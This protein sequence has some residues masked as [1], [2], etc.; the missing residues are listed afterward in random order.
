[1]AEPTPDPAS[2]KRVVRRRDQLIDI[3]L[4][5]ASL[6]MLGFIAVGLL[7]H[8]GRRE[9]SRELAES[10][11]RERGIDAVVVV[12]DLDASG[13]SG[14]IRVGP[15]G[16][17][18]FAADRIEVAYDL[19]APWSGG[20]FALD[21]RAVRLVRPRL[22]ASIDDQGRLNFGPLQPLID[23]ALAAPKDPKAQGPAILVENARLDLRTPGG[24]ARITGDASLD[25]GKLL[26]FDGR[27]GRTR[28]ATDDLVVE[29]RGALL[30][31]RKRGE[32]L[33]MSARFDLDALVREDLE[34]GDAQGQIEADLAYPDL[35]RLSAVGPAEI[36]T[37]FTADAARLGATR[38]S[39]AT[40]SLA[41]LGR[42]DGTLAQAR[43]DGRMTSRVRGEE[44]DAP[45]L[46]ARDIGLELDL[47]KLA[48][49]RQ[50]DRTAILTSGHVSADA[51]QALIGGA[52]LRGA[53]ARIDMA[54]LILSAD[55]AGAA[56]SGPLAVQLGASRLA[57]GGLALTS[58]A[59]N[60]KGRISGPLSRPAL[61][62]SGSA[63]ADSG[64]S[65]PD[66]ER[67]AALLPDPADTRA[68]AQALRTFDLRAP[69]FDLTLR[70]GH[71]ILALPRPITLT[72]A[73]GVEASIAAPRGPLLDAVAGQAR[74]GLSAAFSGGGLPNLKLDAPDWRMVDGTVNARIVLAG[75]HID[76]PPLEGVAGQID[77]QVA[78]SGARS[79]FAL[80]GC[81]P[82]TATRVLV[83]ETP[84]SA[85][86]LTLCPGEGPLLAVNDGA[87]TASARFRDL[88]S[89]LDE[90][91]A[92][93]EDGAGSLTAS[94]RG[95]PQRAEVR[96][97]Q[98][99]L[100]DAAETRRF[101]PIKTAGRLSL[102]NGL[103][104]GTIDATTPVGQP[105]GRITLRHDLARARGRAELDASKLA[106]AKDGLQP[107][108]LSPLAS[109][110]TQASGPASF[111]GLFVWDA[112]GMTSQGRLVASKIDFTSPIGFVA[113]L[114]GTVD[115]TS[116]TPLVS[117]PDQSLKIV[118]IDSLV[119]LEGFAAAFSLGAE[120]LHIS[121]A[122]FQAAK[123]RVSIEPTDVPLDPGKPIRGVIVVRHLDLGEL[124]AASSLVE[125]IQLDAVVDGR[126]P[127]ELS[128]K[129]F[130]FL[131]GK[132]FAIQ[133]GRLAISREALTGV[134]A[135]VQGQDGDS[136][137]APKPPASPDAP[138]NAIQDFAYQAMENLAFTALEAGVT[139]TDKGRLAILFH[140][141]GEHDPKVP[142]KARIGLMDLIR[143]SAFNKRI[144]LPA[145][146]PVDLTLDTSLNFDELLEAWRRAYKGEDPEAPRSAPVQP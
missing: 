29:A 1:M 8:A 85:P 107:G 102:S 110:A 20:P 92:T 115:F 130:R 28:Y 97:D 34:L 38:A 146:T 141:K 39:G 18:V 128:P 64:V 88:A 31:A 74:G 24:L 68:G 66:A 136:P 55:K 48:A 129:G 111:T 83:G 26:R 101:N 84:L 3:G 35:V 77:G 41:L 96:L 134:Q 145:K 124:I 81:R 86:K 126:L 98:G 103:W 87:W 49:S 11:L 57:S 51:A 36:R 7:I 142:E 69:A 61:T 53:S 76:V 112:D 73:N 12:D 30:S 72:A 100:R 10:W 113:T 9:I 60:A 114:D 21:T 58:L 116:L 106:F 65:G 43:F 32:R 75:D 122:A 82:L 140:I 40:V 2:P 59:A 19:T 67:L 78:L 109:W 105:L 16:D 144:P 54:G 17:P 63:G 118:R 37:A 79:T 44:L 52:A 99:V 131:D 127:F 80:A 5:A 6:S 62:L 27:L 125:K 70:D 138:V 123:G 121:S 14:A 25:D 46:S 133:P 139:S 95:A 90:A 132:V 45:D 91:E 15:K 108:D 13:F 33:T 93:V 120:S 89:S 137:G 47:T 135:G 71:T 4:E 50:G 23:E 104:T 117:A 42:L 56:A 119:P 22:K 94:G 143:G